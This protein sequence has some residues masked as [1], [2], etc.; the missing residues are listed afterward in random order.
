MGERKAAIVIGAGDATGGAIARRFAKGGYVACVTRRSEEKLIPLLDQ[1]RS[2]GGEA[3]GFGS[4]ARKE[5]EVVELFATVER[6]VGPVEL[7]VFNIGANVNFPILEM[8]ERVYR[9]VWEMGAY[10]GFL[11]GREAARVMVPRGKGTIIFT[12][13]TASLRGGAGFSAF[14]GAKFALRA[15][16]QSMARELGPKGIHVAHPI[17]DGAIDTAFIRDNFPA[18]YTLKDEDGILNPDHIAEMYWQLHMQPRDAWTHE[19]DL[20][21]WME[22]F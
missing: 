21:P 11:T 18:R 10:S 19:L 9:K 2:D 17:I 15:L 12:G 4:D 16:A 20:R 6:E 7:M 22:T 14:A 1:I 3:R 13:A 8:T 5:E